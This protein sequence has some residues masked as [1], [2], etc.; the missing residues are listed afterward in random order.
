V[1]VFYISNLLS[2]KSLTHLE[3]DFTPQVNLSLVAPSMQRMSEPYLQLKKPL[4]QFLGKEA[5]INR[6]I[7]GTL[8]IM[9]GKI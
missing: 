9:S 2:I 3:A 1:E 6:K 4:P 5:E 7:S 8:G